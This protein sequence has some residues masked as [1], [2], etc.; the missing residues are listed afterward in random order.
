[1]PNNLINSSLF[2]KITKKLFFKFEKLLIIITNKY[3][4]FYFKFRNWGIDEFEENI[5][6][7]NK[8]F[9]VILPYNLSQNFIE[10]IKTFTELKK[11][12]KY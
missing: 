3:I 12:I 6:R 1:M 9:E 10:N 5:M 2:S 4:L 8:L 7:E 11:G